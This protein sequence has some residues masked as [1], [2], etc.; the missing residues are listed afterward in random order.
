[1]SKLTNEAPVGP[2]KA[3]GVPQTRAG[4]AL[5]GA[6][7]RDRWNISGLSDSLPF[8]TGFTSGSVLNRSSF[9]SG[10]ENRSDSGL[11]PNSS[12]SAKQEEERFNS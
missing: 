4:G 11:I 9:R 5:R 10:S 6:A 7:N 1:M 2:R 12:A 8:T 3:S